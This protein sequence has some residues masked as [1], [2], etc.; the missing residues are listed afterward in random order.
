M[1]ELSQTWQ[2]I[3]QLT[4]NMGHWAGWTPEVWLNHGDQLTWQ[5]WGTLFTAYLQTLPTSL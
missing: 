3:D 2:C 5:T 4:E 1:Q